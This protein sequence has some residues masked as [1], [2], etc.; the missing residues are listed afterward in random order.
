M[1]KKFLTSLLQ[2]TVE[3]IAKAFLDKEL[4]KINK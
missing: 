3:Q 4:K 1:W 2:E